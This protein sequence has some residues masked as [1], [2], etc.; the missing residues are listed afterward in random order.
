M[1]AALLSTKLYRPPIRSN[2][3]S[4]PRLIEELNAGLRRK[5]TLV[6]APA[7]FLSSPAA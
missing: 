4:R 7:G 6:S 2:Y 1:Q 5:L 3:V